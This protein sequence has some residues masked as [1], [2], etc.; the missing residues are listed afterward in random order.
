VEVTH[1]EPSMLLHVPVALIDTLTIAVFFKRFLGRKYDFARP[2]VLTYLA[3]FLLNAILS[4]LYP[5]II[6]AFS[7]VSCFAI[8]YALYA[9]TKMQ[10]VFC[11]GLLTAYVFVS[12]I[13]T[14]LALSFAFG[15]VP[16]EIATNTVLFYAGAFTAKAFSLVLALIVSG[17]RKTA[18]S[19][20]PYYY[21]LLLLA[22]IYTCVGLS[23]IDLMLVGQSGSPATIFHVLS[24]TAIVALSIM[25]YLVFKKIQE[26]AERGAY[27]AIV[28]QQ[29]MNHER[30]FRMMDSQ[31]ME[32]RGIKHEFVNH[33][34]SMRGL[35]ANRL[36]E[37]L[38]DYLDSYIQEANSVLSHSITGTP[39][40]DALLSSKI[41][42]AESEGIEFDANIGALPKLLISP[43]HLNI[44]LGA[45]LDN[46]IEACRKL[47]YGTKRYITLGIKAEGD[48]LYFRIAN[49]SLAVKMGDGGLPDTD[50][51]DRLRHG[52]GLNIVSRLVGRYEGALVCGYEGGEFALL[53]QI[54]QTPDENAI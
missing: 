18:L 3:Y 35:S 25:V 54:K 48:W 13:L 20:V 10:R 30:R 37:E 14:M 52:L 28:E 29:L 51:P 8:P 31:T 27:A 32:I 38:N 16:A 12:E 42:V 1:L 15:F 40:I 47:P 22:I 39:S 7:V 23:Y 6:A 17:D 45:A 5:D 26:Y 41:A 2:Y 21:Y 49:S 44:I 53:T 19:P 34:T 43:V 4:A 9:G 33:L 50:K 11:G 46:A 36:Y 24:E